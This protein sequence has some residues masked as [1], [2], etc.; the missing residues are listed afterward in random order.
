M[1]TL[2]IQAIGGRKPRPPHTLNRRLLQF[3]E[4]LELRFFLRDLFQ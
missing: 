4:S 3:P 2:T 1:K